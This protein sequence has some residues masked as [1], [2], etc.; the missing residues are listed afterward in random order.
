MTADFPAVQEECRIAADHIEFQDHAALLQLRGGEVECGA[1]PAFHVRFAEIL[2]F[3]VL[4]IPVQR[5]RDFSP[6][7]I[8]ELRALDSPFP[9]GIG[10][11]RLHCSLQ[12]G[13]FPHSVQRTLHF[14]RPG[15][16]DVDCVGPAELPARRQIGCRRYFGIGTFAEVAYCDRT[17]L[18]QAGTV[19][20]TDHEFRGP[21][22][23]RDRHRNC[24]FPPVEIAVVPLPGRVGDNLP[25]TAAAAQD[26]LDSGEI[27]RRPRDLFGPQ[28]ID[29]L[30]VVAPVGNDVE[31]ALCRQEAVRLFPRPDLDF[32]CPRRSEARTVRKRPRGVKRHRVFLSAR[33][34]NAQ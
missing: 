28:P 15:C 1:I 16:G 5:N 26:Q 10:R 19:L 24:D 12:F 17:D 6:A 29:Q 18:D 20:Q 2:L 23:F 33:S 34:Q 31:C 7:R 25:V 13:D 14:R 3:R 8:V 32:Q 9:V 4:Q 30:D 21:G 11:K 27:L 22:I